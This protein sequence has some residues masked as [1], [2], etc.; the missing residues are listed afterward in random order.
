MLWCKIVKRFNICQ[1]TLADEGVYVCSL[2]FEGGKSLSGEL[3][4]AVLK[5]Q[6]V[7]YGKYHI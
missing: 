7:A 6:G 1:V 3:N 2:E 5:N 4:L